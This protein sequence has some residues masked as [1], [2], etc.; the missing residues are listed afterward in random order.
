MI[1]NLFIW[2]CW[3]QNQ[4][5]NFYL[6]FLF[7]KSIYMQLLNSTSIILHFQLING[8]YNLLLDAELS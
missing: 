7:H 2:S 1:Y 3:M 6:L 4:A 5:S 8:W